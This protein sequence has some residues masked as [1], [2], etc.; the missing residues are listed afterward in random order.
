MPLPA[1]TTRSDVHLPEWQA[2]S[3]TPVRRTTVRARFLI[4]LCSMAAALVAC[5]QNGDGSSV[6]D[7]TPQTHHEFSGD[8]IGA[9]PALTE[10]S[11]DLVL[12]T[13]DTLRADAVGWSRS[14]RV[15]ETSPTPNLDRLADR[16]VVYQ[17]AHAHNVMTLPSH[18][19]ILTG[20]LPYFHGV[21]D[22]SGY[23]LPSDLPTAATLL[24]QHGFRSAAFVA[25]F[26][27]D[28]RFG[29]TRGFE[30]YDDTYPEG[31]GQG[32]AIAERSAADTTQA[33]LA[34]WREVG[35]SSSPRFLWLHLY[36]PHAPYVPP[37]PFR[38]SFSR[39]AYLGEVAAVDHALAPLLE[40][41]E[42]SERSAT[43]VVTS[44]H[45][46]ALGEHGEETHGLF[47]YE[48][49]LRV[50]LM[51]WSNRMPSSD[52]PRSSTRWGQHVDLLPT[53][54]QAAGAPIPTGLAGLS[55]FA[56]DDQLSE[57]PGERS[58]Y[59]EVLGPALNRGWAPLFGL[60]RNQHKYI[61]L[62]LAEVYDLESDPQES[63]NLLAQHSIQQTDWQT[64]LP[65]AA[66]WP[67]TQLHG[68]SA[69][70]TVTSSERDALSAL[71]YLASDQAI[72]ESNDFTVD[73]DPKRL[74]EVDAAIQ[75]FVTAFQSGRL[76]EALQAA[77]RTVALRPQMGLGYLNLA[78]VQLERDDLEVAVQ[79]MQRALEMG[80][81]TPT[82]RRQLA[83]SLAE[84]GNSE[85]G[86]A[87]LQPLI[88]ENGQDPDTLN[89]LGLVLTEA[90]R[91]REARAT[92]ERVF[93]ADPRNP[94]AHANLARLG[95]FVGQWAFVEQHARSALELNPTLSL[96]WNHLALALYNQLEHDQAFE[97]FE[98]SLALAPDDYDVLF[99]LG[100][101]A[102][103]AGRKELAVP[104]IERFI[105]EAPPAR[106]R[107]DINNMRQRLDELR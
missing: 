23:V 45:G 10:P 14:Q 64:S 5:G 35:A 96:T 71:G 105:A 84:M 47:A 7:E 98:R 62:P 2:G 31:K 103:N 60:I 75:R 16:G 32:F 77:Q 67:P 33:A 30:R 92:L 37:E 79:T 42:S 106:Y 39:S 24:T 61:D 38:S 41:L 27:L 29:L 72:S 85:A 52:V 81:E 19:N 88:A 13:I 91:Y 63:K 93:A 68:S 57:R 34:W 36:D 95:I 87:T 74:I 59:F 51:V 3:D 25:A 66:T 54:L 69:Q 76:E 80:V 8:R 50:P 4:A 83:L 11:R 90:G 44:D 58:T 104:A 1:A 73:D 99:N 49:T 100:L 101:L 86:L 70:T 46:E 102:F 28:A 21:R 48:P 12:I 26:P 6:A 94:D 56:A 55:L 20:Q 107:E 15:T 78:Q 22:N 89:A 97:A 65:A 9:L 82:L 53:L 40:E 18:A 43:L 17:H